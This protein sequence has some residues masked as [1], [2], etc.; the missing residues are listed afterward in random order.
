LAGLN[1]GVHA[2]NDVGGGVRVCAEAND[3][4]RYDQNFFCSDS[5]RQPSAR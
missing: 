1:D 2:V 3:P 5:L 4:V